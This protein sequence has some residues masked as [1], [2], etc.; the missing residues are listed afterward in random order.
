M[1]QIIAL[2]VPLAVTSNFATAKIIPVRPIVKKDGP[3]RVLVPSVTEHTRALAERLRQLKFEVE[4]QPWD[5]FDPRTAKDTDVIFLPTNWAY[6][7]AP[8]EHIESRAE[9]VHAFV[10]RGGGLI[11]GQ[12]NSHT[13]DFTPKLLPFPITFDWRYDDTRARRRVAARLR[14]HVW[15]AN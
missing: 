9:E 2:A 6:V 13:K 7:A 4:L 8:H 15:A 1:L 14:M 10:R 3:V 5:R 11:V 12:P